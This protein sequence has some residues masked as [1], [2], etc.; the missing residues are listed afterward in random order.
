[1]RRRNTAPQTFPKVTLFATRSQVNN[2]L[3]FGQDLLAAARMD[4][5]SWVDAS[6]PLAGILNFGFPFVWMAC[7]PTVFDNE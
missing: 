2:S 1:M 4:G 6:C 3:E 7:L 5:P